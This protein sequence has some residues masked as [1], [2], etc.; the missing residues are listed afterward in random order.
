[1][2]C[3]RSTRRKNFLTLIETLLYL[4]IVNGRMAEWFIA[5]VLKTGGA[6]KTPGGSKPSP[7]ATLMGS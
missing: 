3:K 4:W 1:M 5:P 7:T 6:S 2:V